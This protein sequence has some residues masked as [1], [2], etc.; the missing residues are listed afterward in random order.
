[1][2]FIIHFLC[3]VGMTITFLH[4]ECITIIFRCIQILRICE[5]VYSMQ[6]ICLFLKNINKEIQTKDRLKH[7]IAIVYF[8]AAVSMSRIIRPSA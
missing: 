3:S 5:D 1:M 7:L 2:I 8:P 4:F 6:E